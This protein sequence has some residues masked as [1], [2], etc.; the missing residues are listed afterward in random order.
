MP[1]VKACP[2]WPKK[3]YPDGEYLKLD[4]LRAGDESKW[5]ETALSTVSSSVHEVV[6][7]MRDARIIQYLASDTVR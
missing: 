1:A 2:V 5:P 3:L 7:A 6:N 4:M